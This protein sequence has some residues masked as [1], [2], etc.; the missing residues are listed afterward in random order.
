[1]KTVKQLWLCVMDQVRWYVRLPATQK[2][3][4]ELYFSAAERAR[5]AAA[6]IDTLRGDAART[7]NELDGLRQKL[8]QDAQ[9]SFSGLTPAETER[10]ALL[11]EELGEAA[12]AVGKI[13]RHGYQNSSPFGGPSNQVQLERELGDVKVAIDLLT[14]AGDV[15]AGDIHARRRQKRRSV[16]RWLRHQGQGQ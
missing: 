14:A 16:A 7:G 3:T 1:M 5:V 4:A 11:A 9:R 13:L 8:A 2:R 15:R 10:L 12:Q 6:E